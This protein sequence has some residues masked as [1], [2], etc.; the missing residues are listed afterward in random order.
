M[1]VHPCHVGKL[2]P[3]L[4]ALNRTNI[5]V[6]EMAVRAALDHD[7]SALYQAV[8]LD[9]LASAK[10]SFAE[11]HHLVDE[12]VEALQPWLPAYR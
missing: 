6:Q 4:A 5:H 2:P 10:L 9:P 11:I 7:R 3:Q 12:M 1:G 8:A